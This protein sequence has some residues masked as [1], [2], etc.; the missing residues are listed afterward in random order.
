[1]IRWRGRTGRLY[2]PPQ[3]PGGGALLLITDLHHDF[4]GCGPMAAARSDEVAS[5]LAA[6]VRRDRPGRRSADGEGVAGTAPDD[7][8]LVSVCVEGQQWGKHVPC[9]LGSGWPPHS[10]DE[11][12]GA[13]AEGLALSENEVHVWTSCPGAG[14]R[15]LDAEAIGHD[16]GF[17]L[18]R[19]LA[20]ARPDVVHVAGLSV[21]HAGLA[22]AAAVARAHLAPQVTVLLAA[23]T[24]L[25]PEVAEARLADLSSAGVT[26]DR[27][28]RP[29]D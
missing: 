7:Y 22:V 11:A 23:S 24:I 28:H 3:G 2:P 26:I 27:T 20:Y 18:E 15:P 14:A 5:G 13:L 21:D 6:V 25:R 12:L 4:V 1:L 29:W 16:Q 10:S 8:R 17:S 19:A 9:P